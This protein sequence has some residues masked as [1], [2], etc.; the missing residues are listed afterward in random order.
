[1]SELIIQKIAQAARLVKASDLD[2]WIVF[3][4]ET[5]EAADP[6]L[7]FLVEGELTWQSAFIFS[8]KGR[9]EAI[10]GSFDADALREAGGWDVVTGYVQSIRPALLEAIERLVPVSAGPNPRLGVNFS[11]SDV[12]ADGLSHGMYLLLESYLHGTRFERSLVSAEAVAGRLRGIKQPSEISCMRS[13]IA[14]TQEIFV[15]LT[16]CMTLGVTERELRDIAHAK[17]RAA[18]LGFAWSSVANP[19]VN[20]GPNSMIGHGTA[21]ETICLERGHI[22]HLDMGVRFHDYSSDLQRC[23]YMPNAGEQCA[24]NDVSRAFAAV[25]GAIT[26]GSHALV[27]GARGCDVDAAARSYLVAAGCDEYDHAFGHQ[28]GRVAHDGGSILGPAWERYG[29]TPF[30][31]IQ[32][33]QIYTLELGVFV[34]GRGYLGLE[35]MALV[36]EAGIVWLSSRQLDLPVL[37]A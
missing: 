23:W 28:V 14:H 30:T 8:K 26:A 24:P 19:I 16:E 20:F 11:T 2:A 12:K 33:G 3:V 22:V 17:I 5:G 31:P 4:R 27:P 35:E 37:K 9:R 29:D 6:V 7:A 18:G 34:P 10:V 25:T 21:S 15:E 1:M 13:A 32:A 36:D